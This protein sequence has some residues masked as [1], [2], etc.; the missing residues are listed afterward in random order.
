MD[1]MELEI[2]V[3]PM[4]FIMVSI[5]LPVIPY[6]PAMLTEILCICIWERIH[7]VS[8]QGHQ[9]PP[10]WDFYLMIWQET[11]EYGMAA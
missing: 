2:A 10:V 8:M 5:T 4:T 6:L 7:P 9:I 3:L 1:T 11:G